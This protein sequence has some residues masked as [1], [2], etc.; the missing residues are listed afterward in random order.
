LGNVK[1]GIMPDII[2]DGIICCLEVPTEDDG[3]NTN[4]PSSDI[5]A[6]VIGDCK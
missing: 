1:E 2:I 5:E 3:D 6:E 4:K